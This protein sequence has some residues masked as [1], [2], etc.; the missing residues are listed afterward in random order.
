MVSKHSNR[1]Y[2]E[3][4]VQ[5]VTAVLVGIYTVFLVVYFL[6]YQPV[7]YAQWQQLFHQWWMR[8]LSFI[9][10]ISVLWHAWIGLWTVFTDYIK[11]KLIRII[12]EILVILVLIAYLV[13]MFDILWG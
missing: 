11:P 6:K 2:T 10:L 13:I 8:I 12:L 3:W 5:R 7:Y 1:G 9:V 4:L